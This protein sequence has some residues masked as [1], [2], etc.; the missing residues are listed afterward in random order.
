MGVLYDIVS[1]TFVFSSRYSASAEDATLNNQEEEKTS[2]EET[3]S[4]P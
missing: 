3:E 1:G 2:N 4:I